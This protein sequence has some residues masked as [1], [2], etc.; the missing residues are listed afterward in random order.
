MSDFLE[1][2]SKLPPKRLA[3]LALELQSKLEAAE[4]SQ[5]EP[6]AV[7]GMGCRFPGGARGPEAYWRMLC[8]GVDAIS[9]VPRPATGG[10]SRTS[11]ASTPSSSAWLPARPRTWIP[12]SGSCWK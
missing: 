3:L 11:A 8:D 7:I 9:E 2:I 1:R 10:S 5:R 4:R 6:I 12:S